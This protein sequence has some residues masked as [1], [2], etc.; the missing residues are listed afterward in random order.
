M[1]KRYQ[2]FISSTFADLQEERRK[3]I[4]TVMELD[5]FPAGMELFPA[6]DEEQWQFIKRVIDDCD[7]YLLIIGGRYGSVTAEGVS[8]TEKEYDYAVER[9]L[10]VLAF[11]H[12]KPEEIPVGKSEMNPDARAKLISF[13]EKVA[14][15]RLVK[16]WT[17]ADELPGM[18]AL[19]L[20]KTVRAYP[21]TGWIRASGPPPTEVLAEMNELRKKITNLQSELA[22][23][24]KLAASPVIEDLA[25]LESEFTVHGRYYHDKVHRNWSLKI[26]WKELFATL[27]PALLDSPND[28]VAKSRLV[29]LMFK[30]AGKNGI[31][32]TIDDF[33]LD[34]IKVQLMAQKLVAVDYLKSVGGGM[35]LYWI[36]T[37]RGRRLMLE[38]R[39]VR[40]IAE[41]DVEDA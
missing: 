41:G 29:G 7:Y 17:R 32:A 35:G 28:T 19:S 10:R 6:A 40:N 39:A 3:V 13:R 15:G 33:D 5:C 38:T 22:I 4:Q 20:S 16:F 34:T 24:R 23:A 21:A 14:Q 1:D 31:N 26:T 36:L 30:R 8:Y 2:V 9:N 25:P 18:V 12:D 27:A 11:I 37:P